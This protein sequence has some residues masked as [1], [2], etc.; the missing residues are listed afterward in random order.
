MKEQKKKGV[1]LSKYVECSAIQ[2]KNLKNVF[3]EAIVVARGKP[4]EKRKQR[5]CKIL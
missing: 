2:Q 3:D 1:K 4:A 5:E